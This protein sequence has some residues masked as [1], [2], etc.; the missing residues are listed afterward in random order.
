M[1]YDC[2]VT[3]SDCGSK[4]REKNDAGSSCHIII[5]VDD[6]GRAARRVLVR[7]GNEEML[8]KDDAEEMQS[9]ETI[10]ILFHDGLLIAAPSNICATISS[11]KGRRVERVRDACSV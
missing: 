7:D 5:F 6:C 1:R 9:D 10:T 11:P 3:F 8:P 2:D 4:I